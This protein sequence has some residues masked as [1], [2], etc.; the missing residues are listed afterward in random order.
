MTIRACYFSALTFEVL[1]YFD[2]CFLSKL[3]D[4]FVLTIPVSVVHL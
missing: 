3:L 2:Y 4:F 1:N